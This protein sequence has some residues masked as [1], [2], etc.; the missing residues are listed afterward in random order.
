M[1][2]T[3]P[4]AQNGPDFPTKQ[5]YEGINEEKNQEN[6]GT[7]KKGKINMGRGVSQYIKNRLFFLK[8]KA[9]DK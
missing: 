7:I 4:Q 5:F 2:Q 1:Q 8:F 3:Q 9:M 6:V